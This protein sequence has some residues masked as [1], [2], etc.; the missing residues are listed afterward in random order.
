MELWVLLLGATGAAVL[1]RRWQRARV[2]RR[3]AAEELQAVRRLAAE[4]VILLGEELRRLDRRVASRGLAEEARVDYQTAL[5]AYE[6]AQR[7]V[8]RIGSADEISRV[9]DTLSAGRYALA[10]V[11]AR[12]EDRPLPARRTPCFFNPQ[13]G[14]A[15]TD[16]LWT[17]PGRGTRSVPACAQD[18]ARRAAGE[19]PDVR[20]I[21]I[22]GRLVPYW[23]AGEVFRPYTRGYFPATVT[24]ARLDAQSYVQNLDGFPGTRWDGDFRPP[25]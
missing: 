25:T 13:H 2:E 6:S 17:Q 1:G 18:A 8:D 16:V 4:D 12:A 11:L 14:P 24:D 3:R 23:E 21:R 20:R 15:T 5:D 19:Q 9:V 10:C 22:G 7:A